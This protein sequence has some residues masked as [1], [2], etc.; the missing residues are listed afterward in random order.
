MNTMLA[1]YPQ[2]CRF[3]SQLENRRDTFLQYCCDKYGANY[4][5][6][7][8]L[9]YFLDNLDRLANPDSI[10]KRLSIAA[11]ISMKTSQAWNRRQMFRSAQMEITSIF[12]IETAL[13][14]KVLELI[15]EDKVPTPDFKVNLGKQELLIEVKSQ[16][17][18]QHGDKHPMSNDW[19]EFKPQFEN[20]LKSWL[21]MERTSSR[22]GQPMKPKV[23]EAE[24]KGAHILFAQTDFFSEMGDIKDQT[25]FICPD[26]E[27]V[28]SMSI[29]TLLGK[30][31]NAYFFQCKFPVN[32]QPDNLR[33]IWLLNESK[34][35]RFII[36]SQT[37]YL[38]EHLKNG[39]NMNFQRITK[40]VPG[41]KQR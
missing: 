28:S 13:N 25:S 23:V 15:P 34:F 22:S 24:E 5:F 3:I 39:D 35:E 19:I 11:P 8:T 40:T 9:E 30:P 17:G 12:L 16:S 20:D 10:L 7:P 37:M 4:A 27:L 41:D 31:L 32:S 29:P 1:Q 21:F 6:W 18:Q 33:E 26:S 2:I 36:L 38:L 14:G